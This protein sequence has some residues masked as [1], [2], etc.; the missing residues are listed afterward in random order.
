MHR[1]HC[2]A[3]VEV[4]IDIAMVMIEHFGML[5]NKLLGALFDRSNTRNYDIP[6]VFNFSNFPWVVI[7]DAVNVPL[8]VKFVGRHAHKFGTFLPRQVISPNEVS[9]TLRV[10]GVKDPGTQR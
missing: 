7:N 6:K 1:G 9:K 8:L 10:D 3:L 4:A 2:R 5:R